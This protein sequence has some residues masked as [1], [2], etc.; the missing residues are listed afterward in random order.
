MATVDL[1]CR[2]AIKAEWRT[3][4]TYACASF[5]TDDCCV[6]LFVPPNSAMS[7]RLKEAVEEFSRKMQRDPVAQAEAAE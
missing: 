4:D 6:N 7:A 1:F 5:T 2:N 3:G